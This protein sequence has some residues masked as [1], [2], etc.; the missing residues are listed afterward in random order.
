MLIREGGTLLPYFHHALPG[1]FTAC[2]D[3]LCYLSLPPLV[4]E[5][6]RSNEMENSYER[7]PSLG[8]IVTLQ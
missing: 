7:H 3:A 4:A 6:N 1:V 5:A 8:P 2:F